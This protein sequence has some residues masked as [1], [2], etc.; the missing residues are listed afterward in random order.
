MGNPMI[1]ELTEVI[2]E[3]ISD[4]NDLILKT[5]SEQENKESINTGLSKVQQ[6]SMDGPTSF[7]PVT[8]ETFSKWCEGYLEL[9]TKIKEEKKTERDYKATG[10]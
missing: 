3:H 2:R 4:M 8:Q 5:L 9:I 10:R 7:T 1:Y 6:I